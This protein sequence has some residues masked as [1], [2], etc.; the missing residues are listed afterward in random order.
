MLLAQPLWIIYI[1]TQSTVIYY[2]HVYFSLIFLWHQYYTVHST[3]ICISAAIGALLSAHI[4]SCTY[5]MILHVLMTA[6]EVKH[7]AYLEGH[8]ALPLCSGLLE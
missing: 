6:K 8:H 3:H 2:I 4:I 7:T 5:S 1:I